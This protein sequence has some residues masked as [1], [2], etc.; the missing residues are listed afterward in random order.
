MQGAVGL[1]VTRCLRH[2]GVAAG[3]TLLWMLIG[4]LAVAPQLHHDLHSDSASSDHHCLLTEISASQ[5][6][7]AVPVKAP[8]APVSG[9]CFLVG[10]SSPV[11]AATLLLGPRS[12]RP[13]PSSFQSFTDAGS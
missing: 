5:V 7:A 9:P 6:E 2:R 10:W 3:L 4:I 11:V 8:T 1:V 12:A 13:P